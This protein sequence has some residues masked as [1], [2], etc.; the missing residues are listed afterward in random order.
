M[1][2]EV[3]NKVHDLL[4]KVSDLGERGRFEVPEIRFDLKG[5]WAGACYLKGDECNLR[6][7]LKLLEENQEDFLRFTVPHEVAH[8]IVA[9]LYGRVRPHGKEWRSVMNFFGIKHPLVCHSFDIKSTY[10][11]IYRCRCQEHFVGQK[12]H[13]MIQRG[14]RTY[15][16]KNCG[17]FIKLIGK[18][19][20][21]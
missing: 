17:D 7:N 4:I 2:A 16:C 18:R 3:R 13:S 12:K 8:Y 20:D 9:L 21:I 14:T 19:L 5:R 6:F 11:W 1:E 10:P 15:T